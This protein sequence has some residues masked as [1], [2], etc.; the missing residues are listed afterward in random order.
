MSS[1]GAESFPT[2]DHAKWL[3]LFGSWN[4]KRTRA[5][6]SIFDVPNN[7]LCERLKIEIVTVPPATSRLETKQELEEKGRTCR[8]CNLVFSELYE[9]QQHFKTE[10]HRINL[11]QKLAG[12]EALVEIPVD[13]HD[14]TSSGSSIAGVKGVHF[15]D[16]KGA[17]ES[18]SDEE[19]DL[20]VIYSEA[21]YFEEADQQEAAV[22]RYPTEFI[23]KEGIARRFISKQDGPQYNFSSNRESLSAW[24]FT[25][26]VGVLHEASSVSCFE[27]QPWTLLSEAVQKLQ[28]SY[29]LYFSFPLFSN[30]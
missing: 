28:G 13:Y 30:Y 19:E 10:L 2:V 9:Q 1:P 12:L 16:V 25:V 6:T 11:K 4:A 7:L 24:D 27:V 17:D 29:Q 14:V 5:T 20:D 23:T 3:T 21:D 18:S 8:A 15:A 22:G 26:S